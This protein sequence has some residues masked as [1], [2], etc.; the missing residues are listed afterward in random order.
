L[1]RTIII[2]NLLALGLAVVGALGRSPRSWTV[3]MLFV[4]RLWSG[5]AQF[6]NL[7]SI[8]AWIRAAALPRI[9]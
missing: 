3:D 7:E 1:K 6:P 5:L 4:A 2:G 8:L 9:S